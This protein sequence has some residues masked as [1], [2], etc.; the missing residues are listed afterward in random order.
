MTPETVV[1]DH[2]HLSPKGEPEEALDE[3]VDAGGTH[4]FSPNLLPGT[5]GVDVTSG[6]DYREVFR[7]HVELVESLETDAEVFPVVGVH[8]AEVPRLSGNYSLDEVREMVGTGL[9]IAAE[10]VRDGRAAA[11]GEIGRPHY[12]VEEEIV[13]ACDDLLRKGFRLAADAGCAVQLHTERLDGDGVAAV[14]A[15]AREEE[16]DPGRVVHHFSPP[17]VEECREAG[18]V[19]S[20]LARSEF[21]EEAAEQGNRFMLETD[22]LD[23]PKRPGA[24]LG[25]RTVPRRTR[26]LLDRGL[27]SPED[28]AVIHRELPESVYGVTL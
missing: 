22:Y 2:L 3:F 7:S 23:D 14:A 16:L 4:C 21:V 27:L 18:T 25:P 11:L 19:P 26:D 15:M 10:F 12:D 20:L 9:E 6:E 28:A 5:Y 24:V 13:E 1:D 17:L 8:P